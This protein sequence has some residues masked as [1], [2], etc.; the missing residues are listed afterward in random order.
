MKYIPLNIKTEFDLMNSLIKVDELILYAKNNSLNTLGI[1][2]TNM[3]GC[4]EFITKCQKNNIKPI[5][6]TE[7]NIE[8]KNIILYASNYDGYI[9]LCKIVSKK[10]IDE[11]TL[12]Y[13][14]DHNSNVICVCEYKDYEFLKNKFTHIFIKYSN[15]QDKI[16]ALVLTQDI[17]YMKEIKYFNKE[18]KQYFKYLK[19]IDLQK[20]ID[21]NI[22]IE[23]YDFENVTNPYDIS[24]TIKFSNLINLE[25]PKSTYHIP[26][27]KENSTEFLRALAKKGLEKRLNNNVPEEYKKRLTY[28]LEVIEKMNY[29]NYFLIVYDFILYAKK[30]NILVGPGRGSG[31]ASLVN[32]SLGIINIDPLKYD[33]IFERFLN[34]DRITMPDID[35]D[36]DSLKRE[37]V[38]EYV[39][40]KYG[41]EN[42]ARIIS[43]NT[44]LPKQVI[45]DIGRVL[46]LNSIL[47]D[48]ICKTIKDEKDFESLKSNLEFTNIV[49]RNEI[50][51]NLINI[52]SKLCG[53]KKN[54]S[55]HAA[56]VVISD[57]PLNTIMP[58]YKS[59][60]VIL[61]GY[62]KD[63]IEELGLLKMDFLSIKN[64][65]TIS[66]IIEEIK[67][68]GIDI[69]IDTIGLTD[70]KTLDL[71]KDAYTS[72]I[73]QFESDGMRSF[74]KK[75]SVDNFNT[76]VDAIALYR[77]GPREMIDEYILRKSGKKKV[78]Y[79][80]DEL[81]SILKSTYG[82][83]IYQEQVLEILR[84]IGGYTYAEADLIRRA[85]S[86]KKADVIENEKTRFYS[87]VIEKGY[88]KEVAEELYNLIIKFSSYGFNKSHSVVY[89]LVAFQMAY[90]KINHTKY[91]M[92]NLLN[93]NKS[94]IKIKEYI[95]ESKFLGLDFSKISI[96][97]S[98][99]EFV[100]KNN[101]II[102]P[103][104]LIKSI[105]TNV[106]EDIEREREKGKFKDFYDFMIRCY[107][108][109]I[110]KKV[111]IALIECG[112]FDEF[113]LNKKAYIEN[114]DEIINYATLCRDLA[115]T[116]VEV[117]QFET[118]DDFTDKEEINNEIKNYGFYLSHHPVT[119][120]DRST[121]V[122]LNNIA[123]FFNRAITSILFIEDVKT[124][125]T[126]NNDK[127]SFVKL[128]DEFN[129][130]EGILFPEQYK[131]I[132]EIEKNSVF[133]V[134]GKI[135]RRNNEYQ[136][137]IYNIV[138]VEQ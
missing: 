67:Q 112:A 48:K 116:L 104:S 73:F 50:A 34:P 62:D 49:N 8:D 72:G 98:T 91:F 28:E 1:T 76:L 53:L 16:N 29:V 27:Y 128:S 52:C 25:W 43:F 9:S 117:P 131:K 106:S 21:E 111:I 137:I 135:E 119:K 93:M 11:I 127:M 124:I 57:I 12:E 30:N 96:N 95:D 74:L 94:S 33:L 36:F 105:G 19:Y 113:K 136:F 107:G 17:V 120:F 37:E 15:E 45:R 110:N 69:N 85:M 133:K 129:T 31:A 118:I 77:P 46:N 97:D 75:L 3:F 89:S 80:V 102:F 2:D 88:T 121:L 126:K 47:I 86:K 130:I 6:G 56:G 22:E 5:I 87:R 132:G 114:I 100:I 81:E 40:N 123:A 99:K 65:N 51:K 90:L 39:T 13:I 134:I 63:L 60:G 59:G 83:I 109:S 42:T 66:N 38:I 24:T 64:L 26:I 54:T 122:T 7:L 68:D 58:L 23:D 61:T 14:F 125:K 103:L 44:L 79:L 4:Y 84:K 32:Y 35:I 70:K 10:N 71:F 92:K 108:K 55:V 101:K 82:I 20:T 41:I 78:T 115:T 18:D 138:N